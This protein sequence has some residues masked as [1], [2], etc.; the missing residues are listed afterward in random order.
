MRG[1]NMREYSYSKF[2][3]M[4][5]EVGK[6]K[7]GKINGSWKINGSYKV[8]WAMDWVLQDTRGSK[9]LKMK[10]KLWMHLNGN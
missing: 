2:K 6:T 7:M 9:S 1:L 5:W 8:Q 3:T 4:Q 10:M